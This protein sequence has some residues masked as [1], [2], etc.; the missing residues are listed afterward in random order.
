MSSSTLSQEISP[1]HFPYGTWLYIKEGPKSAMAHFGSVL[2]TPYPPTAALPSHFLAGRIDEKKGWIQRAFWWEK[3]ELNRQL[4]L[5]HRVIGNNASQRPLSCDS[6]AL[7][8]SRQDLPPLREF[9][10]T[11]T[12]TSIEESP[13]L[14]KEFFR[15]LRQAHGQFAQN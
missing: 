3:K 2:D 14:R 8:T 6:P 12:L 13:I 9:A 10:Q 11:P 4:D 5:F 1:L 7:S 15:K